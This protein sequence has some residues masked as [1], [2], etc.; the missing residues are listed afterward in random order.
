MD[1]KGFEFDYMK[2]LDVRNHFKKAI[3]LS[4]VFGR[5]TPIKPELLNDNFKAAKGKLGQNYAKGKPYRF[6][7]IQLI[8]GN[9]NIWEC[10][11]DTQEEFRQFS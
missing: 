3:S 4:V 7:V 6:I 10:N 8:K 2:L 5:K 1:S 9:H 11:N